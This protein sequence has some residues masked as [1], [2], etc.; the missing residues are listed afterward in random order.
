MVSLILNWLL[1][2]FRRGILKIAEVASRFDNV[3]NF[4]SALAKLGFKLLSKVRQENI[5]HRSDNV[6]YL[7]ESHLHW[8]ID[9]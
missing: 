9:L 5:S 6:K 2:M 8:H 4:M 1:N 7:P 3:R